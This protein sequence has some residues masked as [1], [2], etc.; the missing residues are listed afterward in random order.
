VLAG[1]V[2]LQ[3]RVDRVIP[4]PGA[5]GNVPLG[6]VPVTLTANVDYAPPRWGP[7][8]ASVQWNRLSSRVATAD[9]SIYLPAFSTKRE[10]HP[11][12]GPHRGAGPCQS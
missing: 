1:G 6:P 5:T 7:W 9:N 12:R 2:Y 10:R 8:A 11:E 3:P 4:E